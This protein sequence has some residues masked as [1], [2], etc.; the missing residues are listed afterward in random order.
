M[1]A[2]PQLSIVVPVYNVERYL[3]CCIESILSQT[4]A[5]LELLLVDDGST[6]SSGAICDE[7]AATDSRIKV[8]HQPN[9][10]V[11]KARNL[12]IDNATGRYIAFV[13]SDD[14][15]ETDYA[16]TLIGSIEDTDIVFFNGVWQYE[17]GCISL[18][19]TRGFSTATAEQ[20]DKGILHLLRNDAGGGLFGWT[21]NKIFRADVIREHNIRFVEGLSLWEDDIFT[22]DYC[23]HICRLKV[24]PPQR[25]YNYRITKKASVTKN[26][27]AFAANWLLFS[28]SMSQLL[29]HFQDAVL[30]GYERHRVATAAYYSMLV[31][32]TAKEYFAGAHYLA[33]L[34]KSGTYG[35]TLYQI[36]KY[37][38]CAIIHHDCS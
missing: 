12:G 28:K 19:S 37:L 24:L 36:A 32:K 10:G 20:R 14:W 25:I 23:R 13:D 11:S 22:L 33:E 18:H 34:Y 8:F 21:W 16:Q 1:T 27:G 3:R 7:F 31:S 4:F 30:I 9:G 35:L 17:D 2:S 29:C 26:N 6:D 15:I 38:L 5:D